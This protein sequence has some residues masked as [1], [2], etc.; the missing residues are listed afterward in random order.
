MMK[1]LIGGAWTDASSGRTMG[2][3]NPATW[4]EIGSVPL[5]GPEDAGAAVE[6][7]EGALAGWSE[8]PVLEARA[9]CSPRT[10]AQELEGGR[11]TGSISKLR[12]QGNPHSSLR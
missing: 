8:V 4:A 2:V 11:T 9:G 10:A 3:V 6:A 1:M 7:A 12:K 5:G